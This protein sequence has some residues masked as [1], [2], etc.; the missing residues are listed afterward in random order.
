VLD[1]AEIVL[2]SLGDQHF[3]A[4]E[5]IL[6]ELKRLLAGLKDETTINERELLSKLTFELRRI[7]VTL[8]PLGYSVAAA[9][10]RALVAMLPKIDQADRRR[11][12]AVLAVVESHI[13]A[14][15][16]SLR[17]RLLAPTKPIAAGLLRNLHALRTAMVLENK[18]QQSSA[19]P[20]AAIAEPA[21]TDQPSGLWG[22]LRKAASFG[23]E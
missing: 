6:P 22:R 2:A 4:A 10:S 17:K 7:E 16:V 20:T 11:D 12:P 5:T 15:S 21:A 9:I 13:S 3:K 1:F 19:Q 18:E 14:I 23:R 8:K